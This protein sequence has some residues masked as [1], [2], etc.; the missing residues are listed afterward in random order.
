MTSTIL[1][2][3][4]TALFLLYSNLVYAAQ[5]NEQIT[6]QNVLATVLNVDITMADVMPNEDERKNIKQQA[7][8][9]Y[10]D[11]VDYVARVNASNRIYDLVLKDYAKQKGISLNQTLVSKFTEKI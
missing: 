2:S 11:M 6:D 3:L 9:S 10:A 7:K 5:A 4:A 8:D 1:S